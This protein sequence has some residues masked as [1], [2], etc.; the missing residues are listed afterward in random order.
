MEELV[1]NFSKYHIIE[2]LI[3]GFTFMILFDLLI[4][5]FKNVDIFTMTVLA[6]FIGTI[7]SRIS[8]VLTKKVLF[9]LTKEKGVEYSDYI[10]A[11]KKDSKIDELAVDK[12]LYRNLTTVC[13]I[14]LISKIVKTTKIIAK[15]NTDLIIILILLFLMIL[16][17]ISFININSRIIKR[18][19]ITNTKKGKVKD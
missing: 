5:E 16:F 14:L 17:C 4:I 6:Y 9:K 1:K 13:A 18:V 8:S 11:T 2:T 19:K 10:R 7:I 12:N 3:P 15:T